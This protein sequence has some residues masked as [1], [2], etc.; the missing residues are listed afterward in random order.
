MENIEKKKKSLGKKVLKWG[1]SIVLILMIALISIPYFFKDKI[2]EMVAKT[3]NNNINAN[4][5]FKDANLSLLK[6][7]PLVSLTVNDIAVANK[8]PFVGDTLFNAKELSLAMKITELFKKSDETIAIKSIASN[9][10]NIN[11][12]FNKKGDGNF[13]IAIANEETT[14][15]TSDSSFSL[16]IEDY[17]F[18]NINFNYID[19]SNNTKLSLENINHTGKGNFA[20]DIFN[21]DTKT[22]GFL[23]FDLDKTNY[24]SKVKI[25]L[26]AVLG[27]DLKNSKYTFKENTGY[28]NQL[29]LEFDGFI[30]LV[31]ENQLYDLRFKTPTSSFKNALAL[32]PKQY[33]GNLNT[34]KTEGNFEVNGLVKGTL[35]NKTIPAF[36]INI[37]SKNAFFKYADLPKAVQNINIDSK[38]VNKTGL[39]KDTYIAINK[40]NF[41]IDEDVFSANGSVK[42][43]TTNPKI[44]ITA[45]GT[46]NL[47][48]IGKVYPAPLEKELAGILHADVATNFDM[49]SVE[50][51]KY[52]NIKNSGKITVS[53]FKYEGTDVANP[54]F[55][56]KTS[57]SFNSNTIKLNEFEAKTGTSDLSIK[58]NLDN[59]YA[60]IF[61]DEV[62]K[63]NFNLNSNNLIVADFIAADKSTN[64]NKAP[65]ST[66]KI[67]AF[68]DVKFSANAKKVVYD[69]INLA[70]V[71]GDLYIHDETVDLKNLKTDVFGGNIGFNGTVSTKG[72]TSKFNMDLDLKQLN[73]S[74]SFGT[75]DM[76]KSIAPIAK[77]IEGK[78]NSTIKV[79]GNLNDDMTPNLKT[80]TG[81]LFGKLLNPQLNSSNSKVLS[82]LGD[83]VD[84]ISLD[85]L[86]LDGINAILSFENGQVNVKPIPLKYKDIGVLVSGNHSFDNSMNY[87]IVFDVPVKYLGTDVTNLIA[88]LTPSDAASVKSIPVKGSLT[89]S[90][91]SPSFS[92]NMKDATATLIKDLVEKQ[93]NSLINQGKDKIKDL[94]GIGT[95]KKDS[96]KQGDAK[97]KVTDK[98]KD[99]LGGLFG[100]KKKD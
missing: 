51:G 70:N 82:L 76:L 28:I 19:R 72:T 64:T 39:I 55:I 35:S 93:K 99:V 13:D 48:N 5:T 92:S 3:I 44:D 73:I 1:V 96:T 95:T 12:I 27:I 71:S 41:K 68:L 17:E 9:D 86:N 24:I 57:V 4:V 85:K 25:S 42:N 74:D 33:A 14:T 58:G 30:Q 52:E 23:S 78:I 67:P 21:L 11:I 34:I 88:K 2:V 61:K 100:K 62:L 26:D 79:S 53:D 91:G 32:L 6:N 90:F 18:A 54:F 87:D 45:K 29:P 98:V 31:D 20:E 89:G 10:G 36:D 77:T 60:F 49:N 16:N 66:L 63:G 69:N 65:S 43:I 37:S 8:A 81:D 38:I 7:F 50:K 22:T 83:K 97:D 46:L 47:A 59:F 15:T 94:I 40:L 84:F 75:L 56:N 80:I